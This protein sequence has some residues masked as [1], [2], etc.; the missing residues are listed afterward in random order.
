MLIYETVNDNKEIDFM[1][2]LVR[3]SWIYKTVKDNIAMDF[4]TDLSLIY[5]TALTER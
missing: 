1:T 4:M 3:V 2:D 5:E